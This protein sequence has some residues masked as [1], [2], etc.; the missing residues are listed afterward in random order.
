[1]R[2]RACVCGAGGGVILV[3][4]KHVGLFIY[5]PVFLHKCARV[6]AHSSV[7]VCA[8]VRARVDSFS[9]RV[10]VILPL[11]LLRAFSCSPRRTCDKC[12][13]SPLSL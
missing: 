9:V 4:C 5:L 10:P 1:M 11:D 13:L 6:L 3:V 12:P 8:F 7:C 2:A